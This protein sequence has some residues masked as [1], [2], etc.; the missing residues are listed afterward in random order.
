MPTGALESVDLRSAGS[1]KFPV[2]VINF[3]ISNLREGKK[4]RE[5]R[6]HIVLMSGQL[7][8]SKPIISP[9]IRL[10]GSKRH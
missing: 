9:V 5:V 4:L 1:G 10:P 6:P 8:D 2:A 7:R 3:N